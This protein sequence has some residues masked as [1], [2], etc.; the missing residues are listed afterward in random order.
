MDDT[1]SVAPRVHAIEKEFAVHEAVCSERYNQI[2]ATIAAARL[3]AAE[4]A[5]RLETLLRAVAAGLATV[6]IA[7]VVE[8][9][10]RWIT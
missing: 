8:L 6:A 5:A 2:I 7:L 1:P 4:R 9:V 3:E 10:K